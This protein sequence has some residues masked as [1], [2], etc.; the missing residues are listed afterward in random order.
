[1]FSRRLNQ[2]PSLPGARGHRGRGGSY[3]IV[4]ATSSS[5]Q[6]LPARATGEVWDPRSVPDRPQWEHPPR[7][8]AFPH[9]ELSHVDSLG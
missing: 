5:I 8:A 9:V 4:S 2:V 6:P 3:G 7:S 1:M